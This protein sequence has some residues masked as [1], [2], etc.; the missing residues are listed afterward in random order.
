MSFADFPPSIDQADI[1]SWE[2]YSPYYTELQRRELTN[3]D[4]RQW[5]EDWS[6][7]ATFLWEAQAMIFIEKTLD[8]AD[9]K[10]EQNF[11]DF[12]NNIQPAATLA[13]QQLKERFLTMNPAGEAVTDLA[14]A[15]RKM[16]NQADLFRAENVPLKTQLAKLASEYD[17]ITGAMVTDWH[18]EKKNLSQLRVFLKDR[19]RAIRERAWRREMDLW[20][21]QRERLNRIYTNMLSLRCRLA[22][23]AELDSFRDY[24]FREYDRFAYTPEDCFTFHNAIEKVIVPAAKRVYEKKRESLSLDT[25]RPWDVEVDPSD[26]P[27]LQP[28]Q[29]QDALIQGSINIFQGVDPQLARQFSIMA[30]ENLL[31]LE[32]RPGKAMGGYCSTLPFRKRPFI[33]MNG[34]GTH[35]DVQTLL[36]EAGH[37]FHVFET[38]TL[39]LIWQISSP[40]EFAEVASTSMELLAAPYL[41]NELGGFYSPTDSARAQIEHLEGILL[42]LPYMAVVDA[43]QHW[44]Y[45]RPNEATNP[46]NCDKAWGQLWVRFMPSI[47][48]SE[49]EEECVSGWHRKLHIF[50]NPF[51]YIEYG[52][53]QVGALQVWRNALNDQEA[54]VTAYRQALA[55]G[56][57]KTLPE[58]FAAAGA[59]FRFDTEML[60]SLVDLI[61]GKIEAL[62]ES[63]LTIS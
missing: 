37:A 20:Q 27:A 51:Y 33:F 40:M 12:V 11:L 48:Y 55:L 50:H 63:L 35:D 23:N 28:Y 31:D 32:T 26:K 6:L 57:T 49:L 24:V 15:L 58:L 19:N 54:A 47:D 5:L 43:F 60:T 29:G 13:D 14:V 17:K 3:G 25:I 1:L 36:H 52:M 21:E 18:G 44:V 53:A 61:E 45:T 62:E 4:L 46:A 41:T 38:A 39:P 22:A 30:E 59:D 42:F 56:G 16:K 2:T 34:V 7:L 10:K 9:K 8:T